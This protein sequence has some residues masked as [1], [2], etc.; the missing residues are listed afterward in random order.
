VQRLPGAIRKFAVAVCLLT[1]AGF[2]AGSLNFH[3]LG[4]RLRALPRFAAME[5]DAARLH[6]SGFAFDRR[7]GE[8]LESVESAVP[9]SATIALDAPQGSQLYAYSAAY[10]L[11]PRWVVSFLSIKSGN[12]AAVFGSARRPPGSPVAAPIRS[13]SLGRLR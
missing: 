1:I 12:F 11:A 8:F 10:V 3:E 4:P 9:A 13:G 2:E 5:P 6:G 7:Y